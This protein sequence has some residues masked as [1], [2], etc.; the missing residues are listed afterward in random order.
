M[1][2]LMKLAHLKRK[3]RAKPVLP[4]V[5]MYVFEIQVLIKVIFFGPGPEPWT[6]PDLG[7]DP[8]PDP[9]PEQ[10]YNE[11]KLASVNR[12]VHQPLDESHLWCSAKFLE[13]S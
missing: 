5:K 1:R 3:Q 4:T 13:L 10:P 8:D 9:R 6:R 11:Q 2:Q 7:P 12:Q